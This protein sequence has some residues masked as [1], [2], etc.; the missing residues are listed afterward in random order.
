MLSQLTFE[1]LI[2]VQMK[3]PDIAALLGLSPFAF[4]L[5]SCII[6]FLNLEVIIPTGI[7]LLLD[8]V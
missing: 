8:V 2:R 4:L 1:P 3:S 7:F 5:T 6:H